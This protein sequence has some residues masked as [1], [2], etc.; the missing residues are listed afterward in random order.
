MLDDDKS[1]PP[2]PEQISNPSSARNSAKGDRDKKNMNRI[3]SARSQWRRQ[4]QQKLE[5]SWGSLKEF[6][7]SQ[8]GRLS[9]DLGG[10]FYGT[11]W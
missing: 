6:N 2:A 11:P 3:E 9:I 8:K 7:R 4:E 5:E 1:H 10:E